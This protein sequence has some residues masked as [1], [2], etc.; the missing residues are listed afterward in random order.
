M[1]DDKD[2]GN[3]RNGIPAPFLRSLLVT[4]GS[5]ETGQ[6]H[7]DIGADGHDGVG[8]INASQEAEIS[9]QQ[10]GSDSPVNV[11]SKV[12]LAADLLIGVGD[13]VVG[14]LLADAV[15]VDTRTI[16]HGEVG[17]R[18]RDGD[19][20]GHV[21]VQPLRHGNVPGQQREEAGCHGHD[22]KDNP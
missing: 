20:G 13:L 21:V 10:G 16:S 17:H 14:Q 7:D 6:D 12:N 2:V 19:H 15:Q 8:A 1:P 4:V 22:Y 3:A 11:S 9:E 5:K 18:R